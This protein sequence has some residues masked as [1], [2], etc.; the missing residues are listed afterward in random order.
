MTSDLASFSDWTLALLPRLLLYPGGLWMLAGLLTVRAFWGGRDAVRPDAFLLLLSRSN[1]LSTALAWA[2]L[3]L[4]AFPG[5]SLLP[6]PVDRLALAGL[7]ALSFILDVKAPTRS[8]VMACA[9]ITLAL[10]VP[11]VGDDGLLSTYTGPLIALSLSILA[12]LGGTAILLVVEPEQNRLAADVRLFAWLG[13]VL[14]PLWPHL[15]LGLA[16]LSGVVASLIVFLVASLLSLA[17]KRGREA[18]SLPWP[19]APA[20]ATQWLLALVALLV[21]LLVSY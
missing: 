7:C 8:Q 6:L 16:P 15:P 3:A 13:L 14:S 12:V 5:A 9:G 17:V 10:I 20:L 2:V 19:I 1:L 11:V 18:S 4:S 21:A